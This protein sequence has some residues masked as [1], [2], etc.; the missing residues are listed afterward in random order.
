M[1]DQPHCL[2]IGAGIIGASIAWHLV[3][4]GAHVTILDAGPGGG[5]ATRHSWAWINA[6]W[7][8]PEAYFR[9]RR[10]SMQEW[11]RLAQEV[12]EISVN[13]S[14]GLLWDLPPERLESYASEHAS[15]GYGI[16]L[17]DR[18]EARRIEPQ[19]AD[20]PAR[21]IHVAEE[22]AVEP[23]AAAEALL[24][25]AIARG[26]KFLPHREVT[27]LDLVG[28]RITG[29]SCG[30]DRVAA[31]LIVL[32]AGAATDRLAM[33]AG[34]ALPMSA[35]PGLLVVTKPAPPL[36]NGLVMA[37]E[38]HIRQRVDGCLIAGSDFGGADP[39]TQPQAVAERI[40]SAMRT[41]L[42]DGDSLAFDHYTV[43]YRP[44]PGDEFP[45]IGFSQ[46]HDNLYLAVTH[47]GIT[48]APAIGAMAASEIL[49]GD[50]HPLLTPYG[51][52]RFGA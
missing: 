17:V 16:R 33:S 28:A 12:P 5:L 38:L 26:A 7:G 27:A 3:R 42:Q 49:R 44:L 29:V 22:G 18:V 25:A 24:H 51:P 35:P 4:D 50:R 10:Q 41:L 6:S 9:L 15:W 45:A 8:N 47:S 31:D 43:G 34:I 36:L 20:P 46:A 23:L 37:P 1:P 19:L 21:A 2:V 32:A 48:L 14:G 39:G 40:L 52:A 11:R 13:W 30:D